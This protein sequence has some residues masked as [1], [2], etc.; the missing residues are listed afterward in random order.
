MISKELENCLNLAIKEANNNK[1]EYITVEHIL[2]ALLRKNEIKDLLVNCGAELADLQN[3]LKDY[4]DSKLSKVRFQDLSANPTIAFQRVL[5]RAAEHVVS[6]GKEKIKCESVL[7]A[8]FS[9]RE[10]YA[11]YFLE[12]QGI[13]RYD[14]IDYISHGKSNDS[15][16]EEDEIANQ[17]IDKKDAQ[18]TSEIDKKPKTRKQKTSFLELYTQNLCQKSREKKILKN[19]PT[20]FGIDVVI[21]KMSVAD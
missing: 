4:F 21:C 5:Q 16:G 10:S 7:V 20:Y 6:C 8:I 12:K 9:E 13:S 3:D 14:I 11:C 15:S 17:D 19:V 1:H 18:K 2:H